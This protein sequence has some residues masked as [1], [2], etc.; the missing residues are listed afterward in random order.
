MQYFYL[1]LKILDLR[2]SNTLCFKNMKVIDIDGNSPDKA[3]YPPF[4]TTFAGLVG[5]FEYTRTE[6]IDGMRP[7]SDGCASY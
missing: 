1:I 2:K 5:I 7:V 4:D 3:E 6:G